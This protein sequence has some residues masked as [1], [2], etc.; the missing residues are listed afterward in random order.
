M[1]D[2]FDLSLANGQYRPTHRAGGHP[3]LPGPKRTLI[4]LASTPSA[5]KRGRDFDPKMA[6][7]TPRFSHTIGS[8]LVQ[9]RGP[10]LI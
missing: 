6:N 5:R 4:S 8:V 7:I 2:I 1:G 10:S 9:L 3:L